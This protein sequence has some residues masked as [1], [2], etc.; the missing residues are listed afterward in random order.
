MGNHRK[1][2]VF[3]INWR[4]LSQE[5]REHIKDRYHQFNN[6]VYLKLN[7]EFEPAYGEEADWS[8]SLTKEHLAEYHRDQ[9]ETN[10]FEGD[11]NKFIKDYGLKFEVWMLEKGFDLTGVSTVLIEVCW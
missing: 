8:K 2:S 6:D 1:E 10:G 9:V 7:S 11:L 4:K 3:I 5:M